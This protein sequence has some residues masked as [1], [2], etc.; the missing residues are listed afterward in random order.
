MM[1]PP[2]SISASP[3]LTFQVPR[4]SFNWGVASATTSFYCACRAVRSEF[5]DDLSRTRPDCRSTTQRADR[6]HPAMRAPRRTRRQSVVAVVVAV[7]LG[8][9]ALFGIA[10]AVGFVITPSVD[11]MPRRV[12]A[13]LAAHGGTRVALNDVPDVLS[14]ALIAIEDERFY[15]HR[16]ID[17]Q[18]LVR[19]V[20]TDL[21]HHRALEGGSTL[22]QQLI[23]V[24]YMNNDD[25]G[26]RKPENLVLALKLESKFDKH[27]ILENYLN[28]VYYG[29]GAY[30]IGQ[31]SAIYFHRTPATLDLARASMLAG[32]PQSPSWYDLYRNPCAA[33]ARQFN[34]LAQMAHVGY[35]REEQAATAYSE[36]IGFPC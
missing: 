34:V 35:I 14:E 33:R 5:V 16:G 9:P 2:L 15:Q 6:M 7:A 30:G 20:L 3:A 1:T 18:G 19:A 17:T 10:V 21:Y 12:D 11:D 13:I 31:A 25:D 32:L 8:L 24:L 4:R 28:A 36:P 23:K 26:W 22:S 27:T 29:H